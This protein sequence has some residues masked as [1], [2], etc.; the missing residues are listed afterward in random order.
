MFQHSNTSPIPPFSHHHVNNRSFDSGD[1][2]TFVGG[3]P[4]LPAQNKAP[5]VG[6]SVINPRQLDRMMAGPAHLGSGPSGA[7][8]TSGGA[9]SLVGAQADVNQLLSNRDKVIAELQAR[10][11]DMEASK[12]DA[13][14]RCKCL[15][16]V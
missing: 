6:R 1:S 3:G 2:N 12:S 10:I 7:A 9:A 13:G 8:R 14:V 5:A 11:A 16:L 15:F 4:Q